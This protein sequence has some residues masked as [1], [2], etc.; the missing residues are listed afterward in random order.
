MYLNGKKSSSNIKKIFLKNFKFTYKETFLM[1][2]LWVNKEEKIISIYWSSPT[3][4]YFAAFRQTPCFL[5]WCRHLCPC[6][7]YFTQQ[8]FMFLQQW[9]VCVWCVEAHFVRAGR[10]DALLSITPIQ[11]RTNN[12]T[13]GVILFAGSGFLRFDLFDFRV[14][15]SGLGL[16][17]KN[18]KPLSIKL[19]SHRKMQQK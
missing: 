11:L 19:F 12:Q 16:Q 2:L 10:P 5:S 15:Q 3:V 4:S 6:V 7:C 8:V 1:N 9:Q 13:G 14:G 17:K 18:T